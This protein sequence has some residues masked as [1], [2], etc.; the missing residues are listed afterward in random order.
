MAYPNGMDNAG[1]A[2]KLPYLVKGGLFQ[3]AD[4]GLIDDSL[5]NGWRMY[6]D[7]AAGT[8]KV[9]YLVAVDT[10]S[11]GN[12]TSLTNPNGVN[13]WALTLAQV[14]TPAAPTITNAGTAA[15]TSY[16]YKIVAV[17]GFGATLG[18]TP[19][20]A[21]GSTTT[22]AATLTT[23]NYN[24]ITFTSVS[25]AASYLIYRTSSSGT[26]S[27]T[28]IIGTVPAIVGS[29]GLQTSTYVF[30]DTGLV[31]D[32]TTPATGN[33]TGSLFA[34]N[35]SGSLATSALSTPVN[36]VATPQGTAGAVTVTY[37]LVALSGASNTAASSAAT[38]TTANATLTTGNNVLITWDAVP[39]ASSY[40]IYRTAAGGTP[41]TTG[42]IG[43]VLASVG[44]SFVDTGLAG[45]SSTPP[46]VNNTGGITTNGPT[47][48]GQFVENTTDQAIA[49]P[50][51]IS[52]VNMIGGIIRCTTSATTTTDTAANIVA[53]IPNCQ[54]GSTFSLY[55]LSAS[56]Q[57]HT[58]A[59][60]SGV[61]AA[62]GVQTTLTTATVTAHVFLFRVTN[63]GTPAVSIYSL[64]ASTS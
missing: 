37:K 6:A 17:N 4:R 64:G 10:A 63:T 62:A 28:G 54:V 9:H 52:A 39:G 60:G 24:V 61:T 33:T 40:N 43:N 44:T 11:K 27:T 2:V 42:L 22:G 1:A 53:A 50:S 12:Q 58:L 19:A 21:A 7:N 15:T 5:P 46:T 49:A 31:G 59:L 13:A 55:V 23:T 41:S 14:A 32:G 48:V 56:G 8:G 16:G 3:A 18:T 26:P 45:D 20:S 47:T 30:N 51:V 38:T 25:G 34:P 35:F 36:V 57:T 29:N